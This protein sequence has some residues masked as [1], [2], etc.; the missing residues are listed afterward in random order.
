V[1]GNSGGGVASY[2]AKVVIDRTVVT[3]NRLVTPGNGFGIS[4]MEYEGVPSVLVVGDSLV[5]GNDLAGVQATASRLTVRDSAVK[6]NHGG[7]IY[8][9]GGK[10]VT[11]KRTL[12]LDTS[13][14]LGLP[15]W[16]YGIGIGSI[17][18]PLIIHDSVVDGNR[19]AGIVLVDSSGLVERSVVRDTRPHKAPTGETRGVGIYAGFA[20]WE[21]KPAPAQTRLTVR[22]SVL[23]RS[24]SVG[25]MLWSA[26]A[27]VQRC[28]VRDT[29]RGGGQYGDGI[30]AAS[31]DKLGEVSLTLEDSR[32]ETSAR[33]GLLLSGGGGAVRRSVLRKGVFSI[34]LDKGAAP[35]I[36]EGNVFEGNSENRLSVGQKL[37]LCPPLKLPAPPSS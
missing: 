25:M 8:V 16:E 11:V 28:L 30:S 1:T 10:P 17:G 32:I 9:T 19:T 21:D 33:A 22:D 29:R 13:P 36:G 7:G 31:D 12:V 23:T 14:A 15:L 26:R 37:P 6:A 18:S 4:A 27:T 24:S 5:A 35:V 20:V 2:G 3:N 34:V